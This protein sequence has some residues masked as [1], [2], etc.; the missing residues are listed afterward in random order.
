MTH[1][2]PVFM[3]CRVAQGLGVAAA[4]VACRAMLRDISTLRDRAHHL[5]WAFSWLGVISLLVPPLGA[6]AYEHAG[7]GATLLLMVGY[8]VLCLVVIAMQVRET[9][10]SIDNRASRFGSA[11]WS[12]LNH[13][14]FRRY[15]SITACSYIG[16]YLFMAGSSYSLITRL[17]VSPFAYGVMLAAGSVVHMGGTFYCRRALRCHDLEGTLNRA[18]W[19]TLIGG[20]SIALLSLGGVHAVWSIVLPQSIYIFGH[21][22]HQSCGQAAVNECFPERAG[23][24][25]ALSGVLVATPAALLG[26]VLARGMASSDV[27]MTLSMAICGLV[28]AAI[29][30][31]AKSYDRADT[32]TAAR[33]PMT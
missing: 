33:Q 17:H 25:S 11:Q 15:T 31:R 16:H 24:A 6:L 18:A 12:M 7:M 1:A 2:M 29:V 19:M 30:W 22:I 9:R 8:G 28:I 26:W 21:A 3:L 14:S 13:S 27:P 10:P 23:S 32:M 20:V 4:G 5:S